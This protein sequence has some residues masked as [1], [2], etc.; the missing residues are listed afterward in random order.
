MMARLTFGDG[1]HRLKTVCEPCVGSGGM[2][3]AASNYTLRMAA[4]DKDEVLLLCCKVN[5]A[6]YAPWG[7]YDLGFLAAT[8]APADE[9]LARQR[10][11]Y[12]RL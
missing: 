12:P 2:L 8:Q 5:L 10:A 1:D 4:Q 3:L 9:V 6:V 11:L 7:L